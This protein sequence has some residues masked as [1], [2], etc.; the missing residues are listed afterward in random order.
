MCV[1]ASSA[2]RDAFVSE[3]DIDSLQNIS[4]FNTV[5]VFYISVDTGASLRFF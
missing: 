5:D 4:S 2:D 1:V 3:K